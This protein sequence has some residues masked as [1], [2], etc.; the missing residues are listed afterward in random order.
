MLRLVFR[1]FVN[2]S[3]NRKKE[4]YKYW[5]WALFRIQSFQLEAKTNPTRVKVYSEHRISWGYFAQTDTYHRI[6]PDSPDNRSSGNPSTY[7]RKVV[8]TA[9]LPKH[10]KSSI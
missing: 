6:E 1:I 10:H 2:S 9:H 3:Y 4:K 8:G 5:I 7:D